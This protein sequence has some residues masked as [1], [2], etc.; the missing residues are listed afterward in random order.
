MGIGDRIISLGIYLWWETAI[1]T[2]CQDASGPGVNGPMGVKGTM[3]V[4]EP[5]G[6]RYVR[7]KRVQA[8]LMMTVHMR[9]G[10]AGAAI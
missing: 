4:N 8:A 1:Y 2:S 9:D 3:C 5:R 10:V 6:P 7:N